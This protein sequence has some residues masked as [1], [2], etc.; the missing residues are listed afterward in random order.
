MEKT[1]NIKEHIIDVTTQL[2]QE[3]DFGMYPKKY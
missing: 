3:S 2:I 1:K